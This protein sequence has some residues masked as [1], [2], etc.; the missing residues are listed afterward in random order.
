MEAVNFSSLNPYESLDVL[1]A[2]SP[3][4]LVEKIKEIRTPIKICGFV[5]VNSKCF[6]YIMGD[7][8]RKP[9]RPK[10]EI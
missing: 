6:A 1:R 3:E 4:E 8:R 9:G 2:D 5:T 7:I 10:K